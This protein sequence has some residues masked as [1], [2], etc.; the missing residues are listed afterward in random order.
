MRDTSRKWSVFVLAA[1]LSLDCCIATAGE[2]AATEQTFGM[3]Y[4]SVFGGL[5]PVPAR[6]IV[7]PGSNGVRDLMLKSEPILASESPNTELFSART[8]VGV[9]YIGSRSDCS[10]CDG[11]TEALSLYDR[12]ER[13]SWKKNVTVIEVWSEEQM[14][15]FA[16]DDK[17]YMRVTDEDSSLWG[18]M[19]SQFV[20]Q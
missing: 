5:L 20:A 17:Q 2:S 9:I 18:K 15:V 12:H 3:Y 1:V 4:I 8:P 16:F 11:S 10:I 6:Y 14:T 19:T 7:Y 13:K